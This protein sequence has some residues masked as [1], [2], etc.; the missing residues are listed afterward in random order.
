[1]SHDLPP[2]L[3]NELNEAFKT[4]IWPHQSKLDD[5]F[6]ERGF[7]SVQAAIEED[8]SIFGKE[9][10]DLFVYQSTHP[11]T[12]VEWR[13]KEDEFCNYLVNNYESQDIPI[14]NSCFEELLAR[15]DFS[16]WTKLT[17]MARFFREE[18]E[19]F[20]EKND[21]NLR[22]RAEDEREHI[23]KTFK[24]EQAKYLVEESA[25]PLRKEACNAVMADAFGEL[26]FEKRQR[27]RGVDI[28]HKPL[29]EQYAVIV[30]ID[31]RLLEEVTSSYPT[32]NDFRRRPQ[33]QFYWYIYLGSANKKDNSRLYNLGYPKT[34]TYGSITC[35]RYHDTHSLEVVVRAAALFYELLGAPLEKVI[36]A[37]KE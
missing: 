1:M 14:P 36:C 37:Y 15:K 29:S 30:N 2:K 7:Y 26:G 25:I 31:I 4:Q 28:F 27:K 5:I 3:L 22:K 9:P 12:L 34:P 20:I 13:D 18:Y 24:G 11:E 19:L 21:A 23:C 33:L 17:L 32:Y 16:S 10:Y 6:I 35:N 8:E